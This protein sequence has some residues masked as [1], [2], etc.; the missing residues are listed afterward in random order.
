MWKKI[1]KVTTAWE[2]GKQNLKT[3]PEPG[4]EF[5][6]MLGFGLGKI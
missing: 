5:K 4:S 1:Q 6:D 3:I 2:K